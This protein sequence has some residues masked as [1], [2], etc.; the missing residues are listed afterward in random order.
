MTSPSRQD[1]LAY[2]V[3]ELRAD[4][5]LI[6]DNLNAAVAHVDDRVALRAWV[7]AEALLEH[8]LEVHVPQALTLLDTAAPAWDPVRADGPPRTEGRHPLPDAEAVAAAAQAAGRNV[9]AA[10]A[11]LGDEQVAR[12]TRVA[13]AAREIHAAQ[14]IVAHTLQLVIESPP[15]SL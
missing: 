11:A 10:F 6:R 7:Q 9:D 14:Q 5:G 3:Q 4:L 8:D 15:S 13:I 2:H 12:A 1:E